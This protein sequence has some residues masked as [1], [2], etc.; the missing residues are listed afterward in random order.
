LY[1]TFFNI[2][3][4]PVINDMQVQAGPNAT[5]K[6]TTVDANTRAIR[7]FLG[8]A[9]PGKIG[10]SVDLHFEPS[11]PGSFYDLSDSEFVIAYEIPADQIL[12]AGMREISITLTD[13]KGI[14]QIHDM[15]KFHGP[16]RRAALV[17][18]CFQHHQTAQ[19]HS[20]SLIRHV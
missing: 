4:Q 17:H 18:S 15:T 16:W 3:P 19:L 1:D 2:T 20:L 11:I 8:G 13:A 5:A 10:G 7:T 14:H 9:A 6:E 12:A